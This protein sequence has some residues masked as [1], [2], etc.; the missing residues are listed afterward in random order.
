MIDKLVGY[1]QNLLETKR[2]FLPHARLA[3][4]VGMR[5]LSARFGFMIKFSDLTETIQTVVDEI[6]L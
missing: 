1:L 6:N 3:G 4:L 5:F 2:P